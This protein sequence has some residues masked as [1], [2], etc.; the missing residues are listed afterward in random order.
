MTYD[1]TDKGTGT[2]KKR[3]KKNHLEINRKFSPATERR[4]RAPCTLYSSRPLNND[5]RLYTF[6]FYY[7]YYYSCCCCCY[8]YIT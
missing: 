6:H 5:V 8:R 3:E 7:Y 2:E 1:G 4:A